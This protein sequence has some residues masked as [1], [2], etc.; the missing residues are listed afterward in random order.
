MPVKE[1]EQLRMSSFSVEESAKLLL[2]C[3]LALQNPD[4]S[5]FDLMLGTGLHFAFEQNDSVLRLYFTDETGSGRTERKAKVKGV[6]NVRLWIDTSSVEIFVNDGAVVFSTRFY[7][8]SDKIELYVRADHPCAI[9]GW[10]L[11]PITMERG[12][13]YV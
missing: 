13:I 11:K 2:P 12:Q 5:S 9:T 8:D 1:I 6:K 4:N 10:N 7:P 3:E